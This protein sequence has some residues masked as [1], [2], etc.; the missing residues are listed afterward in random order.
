MRVFQW[1]VDSAENVTE[2]LFQCVIRN[3]GYP[4]FWG[5][6]LVRVPRVSEGLT[7]QEVAFI[8]SKGVKLLLIYNLIQE[9]RGYGQG[10]AAAN[11]AVLNAQILGAPWGAPIFANIERFFQIDDEWIQGWTEAIALNGY[12]SGIYNDPVTGGFNRAFCNA[13]RENDAI[14]TRNILWSAE[15]EL[16]PSGPQNPPA[17]SPIAPNCGGNVWAWQ[18]SRT[19]ASCP[20]D[21]NLASSSLVNILW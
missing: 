11:D 13:V 4:V 15:P 5:R 19:V 12:R 18:Y 16:L 14:R 10:S 17:Y 6:Y 1:G 8:Q 7:K 2:N 21:T 20:I 3:L 9:A